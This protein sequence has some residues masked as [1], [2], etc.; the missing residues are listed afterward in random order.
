[1]TRSCTSTLFDCPDYT[2]VSTSSDC[3][4]HYTRSVSVLSQKEFRDNRSSLQP[5]ADP[6]VS[7]V[8]GRYSVLPLAALLNHSC[9]PNIIV[10]RCK[11][12]VLRPVNIGE[13]L[14]GRERIDDDGFGLDYTSDLV[15]IS[16]GSF[17][18][19]FHR[20]IPSIVMLAS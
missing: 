10:S 4:F 7:Q 9:A 3:S 2:Q 12:T 19:D 11:M 14:L 15:R 1:M 16:S 6:Q 20:I 17:V 13:E 5:G 18:Q 8:G